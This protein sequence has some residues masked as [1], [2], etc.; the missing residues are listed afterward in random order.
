MSKPSEDFKASFDSK[1]PA[2]FLEKYHVIECL[3]ATAQGETLLVGENGTERYFIAKAT[4]GDGES[5]EAA[6]LRSLSHPALPKGYDSYTDGETHILV[7][8][9]IK[10]TS[11]D[12]AI[13]ERPFS[14]SEVI[15]I[16]VQL[17]DVLAYLHTQTPPV[18]HRDVKPGNVILGAD[19]KVRLIDFGIA[20][21]YKQGARKD[22]VFSGTNDFAPPEQ[23]G[24][25]QTDARA[26]IFSLGMLLKYL[27]TQGNLDGPIENRRL[28]RIVSRCTAFA[29]RQRFASAEAVKRA[30]LHA[31][32]KTARLAMTAAIALIAF[33]CGVLVG[34]YLLPHVPAAAPAKIVFAD[35]IVE[36]AAR[37]MLSKPDGDLTREELAGV[38]ALYIVADGAVG[39]L[40]DF[41]VGLNEWNMHGHSGEASVAT[42]SD[43]A[44]L[45]NLTT[46]YIVSG[47]YQSLSGLE[48]CRMMT[49]VELYNN[50]KLTDIDA[51][52]SL[53][54]LTYAV[55]Y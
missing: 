25:S 46:L 37:L 3:S 19:G 39:N 15:H 2:A 22:T 17:C 47:E 49:H 43:M 30:L 53:D 23:Y 12:Q 8:E 1:Y 13:Q 28:R 35:P 4:T 29:P 45:P 7:R 26:D 18:I 40:N 11:L 44:L 55:C 38:T 6:L 31:C 14:E 41:Y 20:R 34:R 16:G 36:K 27:L 10:G 42:L 5:I 24:F 51:L 21:T 9:F 32:S 54:E 33:L 52:V 48:S 50:Y